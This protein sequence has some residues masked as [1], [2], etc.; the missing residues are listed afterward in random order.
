[1]CPQ[2][3]PRPPVGLVETQG[4]VC[5][6]RLPT[7]EGGS[8][9]SAASPGSPALSALRAG[10]PS[11]APGWHPPGELWGPLCRSSHAAAGPQF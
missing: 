9:P 5:P 4:Q 10:R 3:A 7:D 2:D 11:R 6:T 8:C 1:M